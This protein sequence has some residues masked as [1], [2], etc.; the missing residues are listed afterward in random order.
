MKKDE[1]TSLLEKTFNSKFDENQYKVFIK[2]FFKNIDESDNFSYAGAYIPDDYKDYV[3]S[4][5]RIGKFISNDDTALDIIIVNLKKESLLERNRTM[6]RNFIAKYLK[7]R[8]DKDFS[9]VAY[10]CDDSED[11]RFSFIKK[12]YT[13]E[14]TD[15]GKVKTKEAFTPAKRFS[16]LVG[17]NEPNHTAKKQL[18]P[19][20]QLESEPTFDFIEKAFNI[21]SVTNEFFEKYKNLFLVLLDKIENIVKN[22]NKIKNEFDIK[23]INISSFAKKLLGQIVFLYFLQ[24]KGWLGIEKNESGDFKQWGS[25][26]KDFLRKLFEKKYI[27]YNNFFNDVLEP[28]FYEA[29][30]N[31]RENDYYH[32]L[33]CKI[34]FLNGGLFE[35]IG[36]Y[37]WQEV[38]IP[39]ENSFFEDVF[40]TFDFYNFTVREDEPLE[41]EVAVDPEMLGKV[42]E[43]LLEVKDR[44]SK[45]AFYTPREI[46]HY[47]CQESLINYLDTEINQ[48][49]VGVI[50]EIIKRD[51]IEF[52]I[53]NGDFAKENDSA[54]IKGTKSYDYSIS[55]SIRK[56]AK[57]FD[58]KL[59]NV[60]ICDPAIG[61]G[62]FPV[63]IMTEIVKARDLLSIYI[64]DKKDRSLY[65]FKRNAIQKSIY[66]VDLDPSAVDISRLRL[67][68]SLVVDEDDY[69]SIKPLPNLDYKIMSA[70]ALLEVE[71]DIL[72]SH[73]SSE[74]E[75]LI[76]KFHDEFN[77]RNKHNIKNKIFDIATKIANKKTFFDFKIFFSEVFR[78]N[79][80]FDI[81]IGNPPYI[82]EKGN[83]EIF[84][85]IKITEFGKKFYQRRMDY[86]YF[87][88]A[89][90]VNLLKENGI[91]SFITTN[92]WITATGAQKY[93]RPFLKKETII[94]NFINFGELKIF[95]SA[96]G[97]HNCIFLLQKNAN[98]TNKKTKV[99]EVE[100]TNKAKLLTL[101][102]I[103]D[104]D[105]NKGGVNKFYSK[106]QENLYD[107][108]TYNINFHNSE[109]GDLISKILKNTNIFLDQVC[110]I[111]GGVSSSADKVRDA[112]IKHCS[113]DEIHTKNIKVGDGILV[114]NKTELNNLNLSNLETSF[115]KPYFKSSEIDKWVTK[116]S[117]EKFLIYAHH[118]NATKIEKSPNL[119]KHLEK[120]KSI[121]ENRSQD[122]ELEKAMEKGHW[123]VLTNGRPKIDFDSEKI[124]CPYRTKSVTFGFNNL[125]WF[126]GRD[127]YFLVNFK[128]PSKFLLAIL[129]SNVISF[130]LDK[131]GKKKGDIFEMYPEPLRT[132]P[133]KNPE[134]LERQKFIN[135]VEY[136]IFLKKYNLQTSRQKLMIV[137]FEQII[138]GMF[139]E[140]YFEEILKKSE[141]DI[142][143]HLTNLKDINNYKTDEEK[144]NVITN[145][146]NILDDIKHP[147][148]N[149]LFFMDSIEEIRIIEGRNK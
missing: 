108:D 109:T 35:P 129:N 114:I 115:I 38:N 101:E 13:S 40:N 43:N 113:A 29:L 132:I 37:N 22:N 74:L 121:L 53:K 127:V 104:F 111:S 122:I 79:S 15:K 107:G 14:L 17:K 26:A 41:K 99:I 136:I 55:E 134:N 82:G 130:W 5:K 1:A 128:I 25:G 18:L 12:E 54:K 49:D 116:E 56:N 98:N 78:K 81:V 137:Y 65:N 120:F 85:E 39:I 86:F 119:F 23:N 91:L 147:V 57:I 48:V 138:N 124:V 90:G 143:K 123:F 145:E 87:F 70:N 110:T 100:N 47:M 24:K 32:Q 7:T 62:A 69:F 27:N 28:L 51:D 92:Y 125:P 144:L 64:S 84:H 97:Q 63:G 105:L 66:G 6:Q 95:E 75:D 20:L 141:K 19:I 21:E 16:F 68:L 60:K 140:L 102:E 33:K 8:G 94:T 72:N 44:K 2:N 31:E 117:S 142:L 59:A 46:V 4:Y 58:E 10:Y 50:K 11:W 149:N 83:K 88:I 80:G 139:Y 148:R 76:N 3:K 103:L 135:I 34:P 126:A 52:F 42:F 45:G 131:K 96:Q 106:E 9:L 61:S 67:W 133:I 71:I 89:K 77:S 112:N 30:A 73:L 93:L 118:N 36:N 146:F